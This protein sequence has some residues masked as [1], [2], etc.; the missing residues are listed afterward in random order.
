VAVQA[1]DM[2]VTA[3]LAAHYVTFDKLPD[4]L[5]FQEGLVKAGIPELPFDFDPKSQDRLTGR[6]LLYGHKIEGQVLDRTTN[7]GTKQAADF[8]SGVPFSL[9]VAPDGTGVDYTWG[10]VFDSGGGTHP[11]GNRYCF[12]HKETA[13]CAAIFRNPTGTRAEQ[14][15]YYWL[16]PWNLITFSV[17]N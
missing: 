11:E 3:L 4:V 6:K 7:P 13:A 1:G 17:V 16:A 5:R 14:N 8:K 9:S 15:E 2:N 10:D 12:Y